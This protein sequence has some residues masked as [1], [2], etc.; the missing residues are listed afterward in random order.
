[1]TANYVTEFFLTD[2]SN[3]KDKCLVKK[4]SSVNINNAS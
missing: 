1:M 2:K 4:N 3:V